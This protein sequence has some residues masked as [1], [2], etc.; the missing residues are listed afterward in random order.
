MSAVGRAG[1]CALLL[2]PTAIEP[3][4]VLSALDG[5]VMTGGPDVDPR[6]YGA[7]PHEQ[8]DPPREERDAWELALCREALAIDLPLL[9]VCRGLQV[10]NVS[11][12]GTLHQHLPEVVGADSHRATLGQMHPNQVQVTTPSTVASILG[13]ETK[14][15]CHHHQALDALGEGVRAVGFASDGTVEAVELSG[16]TFA[17]GV[18]W[19]PEENPGD[20]RLFSAL[21]Q[22]AAQY[23]AGKPTVRGRREERGSGR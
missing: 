3:A 12:G 13:S 4:S 23:Q 15:Y 19:H 18:Q 20:D 9:A 16:N 8:T 11:L 7:A 17:I 10:L 1:G 6:R 22:A 14:G 21:V 5:L 2:P